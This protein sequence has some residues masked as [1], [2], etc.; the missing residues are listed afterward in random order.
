MF[1]AKS[2]VDLVILK[3]DV[4]Y[5]KMF[6]VIIGISLQEKT[7]IK[8]NVQGCHPFVLIMASIT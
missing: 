5:K 7:P 6:L 2:Q 3:F 1:L 8:I 4:N